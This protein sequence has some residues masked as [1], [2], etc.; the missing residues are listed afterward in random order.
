V[1]HTYT[2]PT[3]YYLAVYCS[4]DIVVPG[5]YIWS[6]PILDENDPNKAAVVWQTGHAGSHIEALG[7]IAV[8]VE[9]WYRKTYPSLDSCPGAVDIDSAGA[10]PATDTEET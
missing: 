1:S 3:R 10:G 4:P 8:I 5:R 9:A 7:R 6:V 2:P